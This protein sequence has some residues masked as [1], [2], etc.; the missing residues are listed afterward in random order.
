MNIIRELLEIDQRGVTCFNVNRDLSDWTEVEE[1]PECLEFYDLCQDL[2]QRLMSKPS[3]VN[4]IHCMFVARMSGQL[5]QLLPQIEKYVNSGIDGRVLNK[6]SSLALR[7]RVIDLLPY[8]TPHGYPNKVVGYSDHEFNSYDGKTI[9]FSQDFVSTF[10]DRNV[11]VKKINEVQHSTTYLNDAFLFIRDR[12]HPE[13]FPLL[14]GDY[15]SL[16]GGLVCMALNPA[17]RGKTD[18]DIFTYGRRL[19]SKF[20]YETMLVRACLHYATEYSIKG[21]I[22]SFKFEHYPDM[23]IIMTDALSPTDAMMTFDLGCVQAT[24]I[25]EP[26]QRFVC[27]PNWYFSIFT[28]LSVMCKDSVRL[29]RLYKYASR[30]F[31][32]I[33]HPTIT[34]NHR[35]TRCE[36]TFFRTHKSVPLTDMNLSFVHPQDKIAFAFPEL[37]D[38]PYCRDSAGNVIRM[39]AQQEFR[40]VQT[41]GTKLVYKKSDDW[42]F[43][44]HKEAV[45]ADQEYQELMLLR[46]AIR[47]TKSYPS[48]DLLEKY[49]DG[50]TD[51]I[52]HK[53]LGK[54]LGYVEFLLANLRGPVY[55]FNQKKFVT[56]D[57]SLYGTPLS[58]PMVDLDIKW[59]FKPVTEEMKDPY[60][61][62]TTIIIRS[63]RSAILFCINTAEQYS[64]MGRKSYNRSNWNCPV[65]GVIFNGDFTR[66]TYVKSDLSIRYRTYRYP[67]EFNAPPNIQYDERKGIFDI[68]GRRLKSKPN[69]PPTS[70][71][72]V[73]SIRTVN[74]E[75]EIV[76]PLNCYFNFW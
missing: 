59:R 36:D 5:D 57:V 37:P 65:T 71:F 73:M 48:K 14:N 26:R 4:V 45:A 46:N 22:I 13:L 41:M 75:R 69:T 2:I 23:Q 52:F 50:Q 27:S 8:I 64:G 67:Q 56:Q 3:P 19:D 40:S 68:D 51:D 49:F 62:A 54:N 55:E 32:I 72:A 61:L 11:L 30:G 15:C 25:P 35:G 31:T 33:E 38:I 17:L 7:H 24:Y 53:N 42:L 18:V 43:K 39:Y 9:E 1:K 12:I 74:K 6:L 29:M 28:G 10:A 63:L 66:A 76:K 70:A 34:D 60:S 20:A 16:A 47:L 21:S 58:I 44:A